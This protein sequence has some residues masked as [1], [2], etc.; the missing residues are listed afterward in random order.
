MRIYIL[1]QFA[2]LIMP[3]K[4]LA[5]STV[6]AELPP[7]HSYITY[8]HNSYLAT[9]ERWQNLNLTQ[10][11]NKGI[12]I[13]EFDV[14]DNSGRVAH[15]EKGEPQHCESITTCLQNVVNWSDAHPQHMPVIVLFELTHLN[16]NNTD[17]PPNMV[18]QKKIEQIVKAVAPL[19]SEEKLVSYGESSKALNNHRGKLLVAVYRK[20]NTQLNHVNYEGASARQTLS[21]SEGLDLLANSTYIEKLIDSHIFLAPRWLGENKHGIV[22][23][24][25]LGERAIQSYLKVK[26]NQPYLQLVKHD[27]L[28][29]QSAYLQ[30]SDI[31]ISNLPSLSTPFNKNRAMSKGG[32]TGL[33]LSNTDAL[34][35]YLGF[36][37]T[38]SN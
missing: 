20:F 13:L 7:Y 29:Y 31:V 11:L 10:Q 19:V 12:R 25:F 33:G 27:Q 5:E 6:S 21:I 36:K 9:P 16:G 32:V 38:D 23:Y 37:D 2:C 26:N 14:W 17:I 22:D 15:D 8:S 34:S 18:I 30:E 35:L 28:G 24:D 4:L 1:I 3:F